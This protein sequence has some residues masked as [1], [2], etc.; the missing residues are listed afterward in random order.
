M[1]DPNYDE[2]NAS[3]GAV[4]QAR[5]EYEAACADYGVDSP[6]AERARAHLDRQVKHRDEMRGRH[7]RG[8]RGGT[9][10]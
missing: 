9:N 6:G 1:N 7:D 5:K 8:D 3:V 2:Y 10:G 4:M